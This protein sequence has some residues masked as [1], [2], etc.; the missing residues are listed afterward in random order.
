M[1]K[2]PKIIMAEDD[3]VNAK[4]ANALLKTM[5]L[6][7]EVA[8]NGEELLNRMNDAH[9]DLVLMDINMPIMNGYDAAKNIRI[10][11]AG[12]ANKDVP[13]IAISALSQEESWEKCKRVGMNE[14]VAKPVS[15]KVLREAIT[16][17]YE[18]NGKPAKA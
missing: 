6:S 14:Y 7:A 18:L 12:N 9:F 4:V 13:I 3:L 8:V 2:T 1:T 11:N 5:G 15:H 10:G 17:Y 16:K